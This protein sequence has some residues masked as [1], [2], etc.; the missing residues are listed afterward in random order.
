M[1]EE[2]RALYL[3]NRGVKCP[4]CESDDIIAK[5]VDIDDGMAF[6]AVCCEDC[7]EEWTD[8]YKLVNVSD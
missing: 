5:Q 4:F 8:E 2:Q 1:T 6:Q 3:A 7:G